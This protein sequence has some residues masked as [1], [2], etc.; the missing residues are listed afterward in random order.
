MTVRPANWLLTLFDGILYFVDSGRE[1]RKRAVVPSQ[2]RNEILKES[3][4]GPMAGHFSGARLYI[5][6][7]SE[8]LVLAKHVR[9]VQETL[10]C[11]STVCHRIRW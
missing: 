5:Q 1:N 2:L 3:H 6:V 11:L 7:L 10:H 8:A 9:G 4:S